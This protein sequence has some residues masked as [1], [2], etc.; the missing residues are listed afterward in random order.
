MVAAPVAGIGHVDK[1]S[2]CFAAALQSER[3]YFTDKSVYMYGFG[4]T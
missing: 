1:R 3:N 2:C 4:L